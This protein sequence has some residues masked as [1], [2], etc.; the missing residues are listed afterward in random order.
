MFIFEHITPFALVALCELIELPWLNP[1]IYFKIIVK[2][3]I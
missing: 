3:A 1:N 2:V